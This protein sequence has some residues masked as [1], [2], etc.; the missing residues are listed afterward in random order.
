[1]SFKH[2]SIPDFIS[3]LVLV[4]IRFL[5]FPVEVGLKGIT[6][7][8]ETPPGIIWKIMLIDELLNNVLLHSYHAI[9]KL[10]NKAADK[11]NYKR[12]FHNINANLDRI[13]FLHTIATEKYPSLET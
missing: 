12:K 9:L 5:G 4:S 2:E 7:G 11:Y 10:Y 6:T 1:M 8:A 3:I 13:V